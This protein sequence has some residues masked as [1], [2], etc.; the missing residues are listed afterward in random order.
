MH[1]HHIYPLCKMITPIESS[2]KTLLDMDQCF[3]IGHR[4]GYAASLQGI[5]ATMT[6]T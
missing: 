1:M 4:H 5:L 6:R 3:V 2:P